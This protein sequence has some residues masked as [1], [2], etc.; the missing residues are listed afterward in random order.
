MFSIELNSTIFTCQSVPTSAH[1]LVIIVIV[2][3][4]T[5]CVILIIILE[6]KKYSSPLRPL[7]MYYQTLLCSLCGLIND[8][9]DEKILI[10]N[11]GIF[12]KVKHLNLIPAMLRA[13]G[14]VRPPGWQERKPWSTS[15]I[16]E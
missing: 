2:V 16:S 13:L 11:N 7:W 5:A 4:V 6:F 8:H 10:L 9:F 1:V 14:S 15:G 3:V 12:K